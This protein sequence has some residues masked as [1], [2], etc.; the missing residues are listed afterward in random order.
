MGGA[1]WCRNDDY[2][3]A[4]GVGGDFKYEGP[5]APGGCWCCGGGPCLVKS[6]GASTL[7]CDDCGVWDAIFVGRGLDIL[8]SRRVNS[9]LQVTGL[10]CI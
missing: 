8:G 10:G 3:V 6:F 9:L 5:S 7:E 1:L 2:G 4:G